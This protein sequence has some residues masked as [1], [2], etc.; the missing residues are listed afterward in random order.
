MIRP[1]LTIGQYNLPNC[2]VLAPMA[3]VTDLPFRELAHRF[4]AGMVV[5]EML[6]SDKKLW[7]SRKSRLRLQLGNICSPKVVQIAGGDAEMLADAASQVQQLGAEIIDINMGCPA[8]KV[9]NKAAGSALLRDEPLVAELLHAVIASVDVPVTLKIR[10]GWSPDSVNAV[11]IA[12]IAQRAGVSALTVHGRTRA[13]RFVGPVDYSAIAAVKRA[14]SI[15]VIAN[16]D[17]TDALT[18]E[19]VL[20]STGADGVMLG[21]A[22]LGRP[23]LPGHI[24]QYLH[25]GLQLPKPNVQDVRN[26]LLEHLA[27]LHAFYDQFLGTRIA[28][29][30]VG[31]YLQYIPNSD[32]FRKQFNQ[33]DSATEQLSRIAEFFEDLDTTIHTEGLAA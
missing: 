2:V 10:T 9:C 6:T 32:D 4:G 19:R 24:A 22:A 14:V 21:R 18:A 7:N 29:K 3:G 28:R 5:A 13:C 31:W 26:L 33:I 23:W 1:A 12:E 8:K 15:P 20:N 27:S 11:R 17:I 25:K 30:H 16:G